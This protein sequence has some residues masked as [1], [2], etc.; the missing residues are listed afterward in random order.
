MRFHNQV[1]RCLLNSVYVNNGGPKVL[2]TNE[3]ES[4]F[5]RR[6][7][8]ILQFQF[9]KLVESEDIRFVKRVVLYS[10]AITERILQRLLK[11]DINLSFEHVIE[12][13]LKYL[14][15]MQRKRSPLLDNA[16]FSS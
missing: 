5:Y 1:K 10:D 7:T 13:K 3:V 11:Y 16:R 15:I 8:I 14:T 9:D 2:L 4:G 6:H 12:N